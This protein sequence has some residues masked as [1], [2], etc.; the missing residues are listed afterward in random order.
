MKSDHWLLIRGLNRQI[1]HWADFPQ[2]LQAALP[3]QHVHCL[4]LPGYGEMAHVPSP[5][6]IAGITENLRQQWL[7]RGH[8][9]PVKLLSISLGGMVAR[10]WMQT[11]PDEVASAVLINTSAA[12]LCPLWQR[13]R[14]GI[15]P[16]FIRSLMTSET[17]RIE[18]IHG[19]ISSIDPHPGQT[20][21]RWL[22][23]QQEQPFRLSNALRQLWAA[24]RFHPR[25][26]PTGQ[27]L[28]VLNSLGDHMVNPACSQRL[29]RLWQA[30][31]QTHPTA[32]HDL[33]LDDPRWVIEKVQHWHEKI[34]RE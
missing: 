14:P 3:G 2:Q 25:P 1:R 16:R 11:W 4:D 23:I 19:I 26:G 18:I 9:L 32:G 5:A 31:L 13:L 27:P 24:Y 20:R 15:W 21:K 30:E 6:S 17:R 22:Q 28:L 8:P 10:Y 33:P 7:D 12:G 29:A 34:T